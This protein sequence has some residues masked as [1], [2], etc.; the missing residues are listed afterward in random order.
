MRAILID[1]EYK[2]ITEVDYNG[3]Y[4]HIY[5]LI[6]CELYTIVGLHKAHV[7]FVDEEGLLNNPRYFFTWEGYSTSLANKGLI[8]GPE[9]FDEGN[10]DTHTTQCTFT[11]E[12]VRQKIKF[13]ELSVQGF[14][15]M[16]GKTTFMGKEAT[17][18]EVMPIFGPPKETEK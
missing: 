12:E 16:E 17:L 8:L 1:P 11:I 5:E 6:E 9:K 4:S 15:Q 13:V 14:E 2:T 10:E 18:F 7:L 3:N